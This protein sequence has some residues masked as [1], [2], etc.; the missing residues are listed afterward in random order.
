M[1]HRSATTDPTGLI[2][3]AGFRL[4]PSRRRLTR[5]DEPVR[6]GARALDLLI[7]LIARAGEVVGKEELF[8]AVWPKLAIDESNLRVH[9]SALR[10]LLGDGGGAVPLI[11]S[12]PGR[13]Y[14][15]VGAV[16]YGSAGP[17]AVA[18]AER[19]SIPMLPVPIIGRDQVV[20]EI[21][22]RLPRRRFITIVGAGGIGKTAVARAV[23]AKVAAD[24]RDGVRFVDFGVLSGP[25]LVAAHLA[26]LLRLP[27]AGT[28]PLDAV[29]AYLQTQNMLLMFDNCE[30][31]IEVASEIAERIVG[32]APEVSIIATSREPLRAMG[33]WVQRLDP[34]AVPPL[35]PTLTAAEI[36]GFPAV[37]LF[38]ER[39]HAANDACEITDANA[40]LAAEIC[41]RL[42]GLPLAVELAAASVALFGFARVVERLDDRFKLL[43]KGRR[44]SL[45]RHQ[46]LEAMIDWSY[47]NLD[48][49]EKLVWRRLAVFAGT[50]TLEAATEIGHAGGEDFDVADIL[51]NLVEKSLVAID[52]RGND[53]RY[54]LLESLRLYA[55][56]K[57]LEHHEAAC[58]R[59]RH[60]RYFYE[61]S[62]GSGDNWVETP[63]EHWLHAH[64]GDIADLRAALD[65]AFSPEGDPVFAAK[66]A[67]ASAPFWFKLLLVPELRR[68]LERAL[69]LA[70]DQPLIDEAVL[71]RLDIALA[72][73]IFHTLG[74]LSEVG[75]S[76]ES[77]L[78]LA[79]RS[80]DVSCQLQIL[81]A[82]FGIYSTR[83]DYDAM[84][85]WVD[86]VHAMI[87]EHPE[88]PVEPLY[89]RIA[90]LAFHLLGEQ[91]KALR[92]AEAALHHPSIQRRSRRDGVFFYDH[93]TATNSHYCRILW[94][95]GRAE[96][97]QAVV[98]ATIADALTIDQPFALGFFLVH[99]AGPVSFWTGD[100]EALEA[101]MALL[102][103]VASGITFNVW[104]SGGRIYEQTLTLLRT[105]G[106]GR[107]SW[108]DLPA[109]EVAMTPFLAQSLATFDWR[110]LCP[111]LAAET[112]AGAVNWCT[113][114]ILRA[115]G[116]WVLERSG[117]AAS[118]EA[119]ELFRHSIDLARGQG[120]LAWEL[121]AAASLARL[122]R[123][124]GRAAQ[125]SDLLGGVYVRFTEG[126]ATPDLMAAGEL[127]AEV[128]SIGCRKGRK[129]L[130]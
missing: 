81:W 4:Q 116:E 24:F 41:V 29:V 102:R 75:K 98:R 28:Q 21:A 107:Y 115:K 124:N 39:L 12:V 20:E 60:A 112:G 45:P 59:D 47:Q 123:R 72:H 48:D 68:Y 16:T 93:K 37:Q 109:D 96:A 77:A 76:L 5:D 55:F 69:W 100:L 50:F 108:R 1:D 91:Q 3:F 26:S 119:E 88:L 120:A 52:P 92:H 62:L 49:N 6:I 25:A 35:S 53:F 117:D 73:S 129:H 114:E 23:M 79:E 99:G 13:G 83:G 38:A 17:P 30:H 85:P 101:Q 126:F 2:E 7:A 40:P 84:M 32:A 127:L 43:T 86:R 61:R 125:A 87:D 8:A 66:L 15:F 18:P 31:V 94:V 74:P 118:Q 104:Q 63:S 11:A 64:S 70:H 57:L 58:V 27:A 111:E 9:V 51:G 121:R 82:L 89:D 71:M 90:A 46:T 34:L 42:D 56:G 67:S 113:A 105:A 33:E 80:A 22:G 97:A 78:A 10:K 130:F 44:T 95:T 65:W 103:D 19:S 36:I 128:K 122:W 54:R 110:L 106:E 14:S